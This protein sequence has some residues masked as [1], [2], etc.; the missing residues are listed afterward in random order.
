MS[1]GRKPEPD[2]PPTPILLRL[3]PALGL[4]LLAGC[5]E[6][7]GYST[8]DAIMRTRVPTPAG[9]QHG[10]LFRVSRFD[11]LGA[12][13]SAG[14]GHELGLRD[15]EA[16][17]GNGRPLRSPTV[18]ELTVG[19]GSAS[20]SARRQRHAE[21]PSGAVRGPQGTLQRDDERPSLAC[22]DPVLT[23][24]FQSVGCDLRMAAN[25]ALSGPRQT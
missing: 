14:V 18:V 22:C 4:L 24:D 15:N 17:Q 7:L 25:S 1:R 20:I 19:P 12:D 8:R 13:P 2:V 10:Q 23:T 6:G 11:A 16:V 9:I 21:A 3:L 5:M